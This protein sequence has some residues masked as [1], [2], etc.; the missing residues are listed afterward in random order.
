M[1]KTILSLIIAVCLLNPSIQ[2]FEW[3]VEYTNLVST[4]MAEDHLIPWQFSVI[5][6]INNNDRLFTG[7]STP[8]K[9]YGTGQVDIA[10]PGTYEV[11]P[12]FEA[13]W[14][15]G[16]FTSEES[17]DGNLTIPDQYNFSGLT[18]SGFQPGGGWMT[19]ITFNFYIYDP[20]IWEEIYLGDFCVDSGDFTDNSYDWLFSPPLPFGGPY[21]VPVWTAPCSPLIT[22]CPP[23]TL[24][25]HIGSPMSYDFEINAM[26]PDEAWFQMIS[27][28]GE[29][30]TQTG[31]WSFT[32]AIEDLG[33]HTIHIILCEP[34]CSCSNCFFFIL[35]DYPCGD[36]NRDGVV[37][38]L[39]ISFLI[40]YLYGGGPAPEPLERG[41]LNN[42]GAVNLLDIT[43]LI[44]FLYM[45]GDPIEC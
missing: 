45:G 24:T 9:F 16:V 10:I 4:S 31:L 7:W 39:D 20:A 30:D 12:D 43:R 37:N 44:D 5:I 6:H 34:D 27:G 25:G 19:M 8:F 29:I 23:D 22:N 17:W 38:I 42:D 21:C 14:T 32:P 35:I 40:D 33:P 3:E 28:P 1:I 15:M 26:F 41:D 13:I 18:L 2:A 36:V 11:N